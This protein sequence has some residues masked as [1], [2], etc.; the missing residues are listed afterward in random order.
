M[1]SHTWRVSLAPKAI[2]WHRAFNRNAKR[3]IDGDFS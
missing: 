3:T 1:E 2:Q